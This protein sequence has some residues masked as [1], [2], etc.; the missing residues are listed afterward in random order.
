MTASSWDRL[1]VLRSQFPRSFGTSVAALLLLLGANIFAASRIWGYSSEVRR[2]RDGM[3]EAARLRTDLALQSEANRARVAAELTR[4]KARADRELHLTVDVDSARMFLERDGVVLREMPAAL[5]SATE[6]STG[7]DS[8]FGAGSDGALIVL[9][10]LGPNDKWEIP[11]GVFSDKSLP[12]PPDRRISGALGRN[13]ILLSQGRVIYAVPKLG[14][15]ADSTYLLPGSIRVRSED[16]RAI[17]PNVA[18]GMTVY[19]YD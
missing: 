17:A 19:F 11:V 18:P 1:R 14:P 6:P 3:S 16:L 5:A 4:Q 9:A 7:A 13:A 2:L 8:A 15:L 10:V 12:V